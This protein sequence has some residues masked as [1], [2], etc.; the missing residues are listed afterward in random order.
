MRKTGNKEMKICQMLYCIATLMIFTSC[1][2]QENPKYIGAEYGVFD[3]DK[4][5]FPGN[6][7]TLLSKTEKYYKRPFEDRYFDGKLPKD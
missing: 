7:D 6:L 5:T 4:V 3:L 2:S 1:R